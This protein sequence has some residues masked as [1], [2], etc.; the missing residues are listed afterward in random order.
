M[1][2]TRRL[3]RM[4]K[5]MEINSGV[6]L[7]GA[8]KRSGSS[9]LVG[10]IQLNSQLQIKLQQCNDSFSF[11]YTVLVVLELT[12]TRKKMNKKGIETKNK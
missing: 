6:N 3:D 2:R 5:W 9:I 1:E 4:Q 10:M 11:T 8:S 7:A 12:C